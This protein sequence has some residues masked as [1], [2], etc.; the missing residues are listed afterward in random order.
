MPASVLL[1]AAAVAAAPVSADFDGDRLPDRAYLR[2][3]GGAYELVVERGA[4]GSAVIHTAADARDFNFGVLEPG[5]YATWCGKKAARRPDRRCDEAT[6]DLAGATLEFGTKE[7][8]QAVAL[9]DDGRF[10]VVW[11]SD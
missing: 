5:T 11:L 6:V 8:S 10:R 1:A 3:A 9:W 4:G 2:E 7:A